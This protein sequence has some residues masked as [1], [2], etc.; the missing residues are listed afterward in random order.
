MSDL[1]A[2][3]NTMVHIDQA[4]LVNEDELDEV[5]DESSDAQNVE[6][7]HDLDGEDEND[8]P[9][10]SEIGLSKDFPDGPFP[11]LDDDDDPMG[12]KGSQELCGMSDMYGEDPWGIGEGDME[13]PDDIQ[14]SQ[15]DED[16]GPPDD[17]QMT[18]EYGSDVREYTNRIWEAMDEGIIDPRG[19]AEAAL[20][21]LSE[22]QVHDMARIND[23]TYILGDYDDEDD[24]E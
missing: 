8:S 2:L 18:N 4:V 3:L 14:I 6:W 5:I 24:D 23:W 9:K 19:V 10:A 20:S 12:I 1:R 22:D 17:I 15:E 21:Y 16:F 7:N 13:V 11:G